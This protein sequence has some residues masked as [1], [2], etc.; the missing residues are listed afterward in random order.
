[1]DVYIQSRYVTMILLF[2]EDDTSCNFINQMIKKD[3]KVKINNWLIQRLKNNDV[4]IY[5]E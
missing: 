3:D 4:K 1:M 2:A 5:Y